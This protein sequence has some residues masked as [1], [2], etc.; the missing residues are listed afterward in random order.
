MTKMLDVLGDYLNLKKIKFCRLD[1]SMDFRDRQVCGLSVVTF[2][3]SV[4]FAPSEHCPLPPP[5][6]SQS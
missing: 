3:K 4:C 1:G 5:G 2:C 6:V